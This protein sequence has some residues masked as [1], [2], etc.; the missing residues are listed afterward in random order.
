MAQRGRR[1]RDEATNVR[2]EQET[3]HTNDGDRDRDGLM[4]GGQCGGAPTSR[5]LIDR[6]DVLPGGRL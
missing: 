5:S 4:N 3:N 2:V 1:V 6:S